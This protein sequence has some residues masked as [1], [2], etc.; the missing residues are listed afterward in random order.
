MT[1]TPPVTALTQQDFLDLL[2][3][4]LPD[5]YLRAIRDVGPGYELLQS[6]AA[7]FA[8]LSEAVEVLGRDSFIDLAGTDSKAIGQVELFRANPNSV[9]SP[10][11]GQ[12]GS[13][14]SIIAGAPA[15]QMRVTGLTNMSVASVGNFLKVSGASDSNNVGTFEIATFVDVST[16]DVVNANVV[17][18]DFAGQSGGAASIVA[19][20]AG[21]EM[22]VTGLSGM[23]GASVGRVLSVTGAASTTNNGLFQ[24][25][26]FNSATSVDVANPAAVVPDGNNGS[27]AWEEA[28]DTVQWQEVTRT[29]IVKAGTVVRA[30]AGGQRFLTTA[31]VTFLPADVGPFTVAIEAESKGHEWNLPGQAAAAD[32]TILEGEIDTVA[33]LVEEPP[34]GDVTIEVRQIS[35]TTGGT[36]DALAALGRNRGILQGDGEETDTYR[37]RIRGLPDTISPA[38]FERTVRDLLLPINVGFSIIETFNVSYQTAY[39][40]PNAAIPGSFFDPNL[41]VYDDPDADA[42][43]F[44][45]RWLDENDHRG[46]VIVVI[47]PIQP[48]LDTGMVYDDTVPDVSSLV[49]SSTGG[50]RAV[51]AY[52]V[53]SNLGFGAVQGAYDGDDYEKNALVRGLFETLQGI[54]PSGSSVA[55]ERLGE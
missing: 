44:R 45:N 20:A 13:A 47:D 48:L 25:T 8:R 2:E 28:F 1:L 46:G 6:Y 19:G 34:L 49:S 29:V 53:P 35:P 41:F 52:D 43:P 12:S 10:I 33:V 9:D 3:R 18:P 14:A 23:T 15:G 54:K 5:P 16:V 26:V 31:D 42:D 4:I 7:M 30:S 32:G 17:I 21:G 22:R 50:L 38:A 37:I 24:I 11:D 51:S 36:D 27:I 39:D 40:A 55:L